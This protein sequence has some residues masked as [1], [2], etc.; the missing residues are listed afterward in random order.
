[1]NVEQK[2]STGFFLLQWS[3]S[4]LETPVEVKLWRLVYCP[5]SVVSDPHTLRSRN[6][7]LGGRVV[8]EGGSGGCPLSYKTE[9]KVEKW[10]STVKP[11]K[12]EQWRSS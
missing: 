7:L 6:P 3:S 2:K 11:S 4:L 8:D 1:M 12:R 9:G 10:G 5:V